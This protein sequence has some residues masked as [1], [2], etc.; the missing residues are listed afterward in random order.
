MQLLP[1]IKKA[2]LFSRDHYRNLQLVRMQRSTD[3]ELATPSLCI[4]ND[5]PLPKT[6]GTSWKR[7]QKDYKNPKTRISAV[8]ES[9]LK[10]QKQKQHL[11]SRCTVC[12]IATI[13]QLFIK[14][15]VNDYT[16]SQFLIL[17]IF[18]KTFLKAFHLI[19]CLF[20]NYSLHLDCPS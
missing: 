3:C 7:G 17:T 4:Y 10:K 19:S 1:F 20:P 12:F 2:P 14:C 5:T 11:V 18:L 9:L 16:G 8:G 6:Q 15:L 13:P